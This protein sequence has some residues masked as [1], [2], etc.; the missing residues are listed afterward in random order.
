MRNGAMSE[1]HFAHFNAVREFDN[2]RIILQERL[3][4][5]MN[6][7]NKKKRKRDKKNKKKKN[8]V[9]YDVSAAD[10]YPGDG[11]DYKF[12]VLDLSNPEVK[13]EI[14]ET[15]RRIGI[16]GETEDGEREEGKEE[17]R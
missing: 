1:V 3:E 9:D 11:S 5:T 15:K 2:H 17:K 14:D 6:N 7:I 10:L 8:E 13:A 16:R 12:T 4:M